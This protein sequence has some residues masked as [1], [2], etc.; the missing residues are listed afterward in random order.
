MNAYFHNAR[1]V[2]EARQAQMAGCWQGAQA[3]GLRALV[4]A[5]VAPERIEMCQAIQLPEVVQEL[6][7]DAEARAS[8]P[9]RLPGSCRHII[10][11]SGPTASC[12]QPCR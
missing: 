3:V 10:M 8:S 2:L 9:H 5:C 7:A 11:Q 4:Q 12:M 6:T 1:A